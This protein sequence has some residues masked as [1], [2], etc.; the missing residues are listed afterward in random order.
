MAGFI[1][2]ENRT[3]HTLFPDSLD[4]YIHEDN[5][6]RVVD[7]FVDMLD[8]AH[9]GF[10]RTQPKETGR[11]GYSPTTLLKLYLYGY[12]NRIQ[13]SRRLE[14]EAHRN[15]ELMWL[16]QRLTP[17]FK[18][19]A[20]FRRDN[21]TGIK[22]ACKDFIHICRQMDLFH[23][24]IVAIDGSKF[25]AVNSSDRN[26]TKS[27][28]QRRIDRVE[29]NIARYLSRL[30]EADK[31]T[32][33]DVKQPLQQKL[34][35]LKKHLS[36]LRTIKQTIESGREQQVSLTDPD[37]RAMKTQ[38]IGRTIGYNVQTAVD[39]KHHLIIS[40]TVTNHV[41]DRDELYRMGQKAQLSIGRKH[42]TVIA[43]KGY[44]SGERIKECQEAGITPY[45]AR[46]QTSENKKLGL[47]SK[48]DF[49]YDKDSD[50]YHC[51][52]G[53]MIPF[54]GESLDRTGKMIRRYLSVITCKECALKSQCTRGV[55]RRL[56]RWEH[57]SCLEAMEA[58]IN[59]QPELMKL[60]K[61]TV[62]HP[63]GT[64]KSW[65]GATHFLTKGLNQVSTE[66]SLHVL[67]YNMK[68]MLNIV[69]QQALMNAF[70]T[71]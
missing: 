39:T 30:D 28:I 61:Q 34:R 58:Q 29:E 33:P 10:N 71:K 49:R 19:I 42:I 27:N 64:I 2:G 67:A 70:K 5:P 37:C 22:N 36:K 18:T 54:S 46:T 40:H 6:V 20:D 53:K 63:F 32:K 66:M 50:A 47:F 69:G 43:D 68:R 45:V 13:S 59:K 17:D 48:D 62:E 11:P 44:Y 1:E 56:R 4:N 41:S 60:R 16:L 21:G 38:A 8:L 51:P 15:V 52:A 25:K 12:L 23:D 9:M 35:I 3:Q 57:E 26:F 24:T 65:M 31:N 7:A 55:A 14:R